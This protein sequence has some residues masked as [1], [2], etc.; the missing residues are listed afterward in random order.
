MKFAGVIERHGAALSV[1]RRQETLR[2]APQAGAI[3][4]V[5]IPVAM[6]AAREQEGSRLAESGRKALPLQPL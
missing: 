3:A 6:D 4:T 2:I 1:R 5:R